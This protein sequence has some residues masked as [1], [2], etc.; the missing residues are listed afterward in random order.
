MILVGEGRLGP[1]D[2]VPSESIGSRCVE[3]VTCGAGIR[4]ATGLSSSL[5]ISSISA[6]VGV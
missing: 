1:S 2:N 3:R 4:V 5:R 6:S